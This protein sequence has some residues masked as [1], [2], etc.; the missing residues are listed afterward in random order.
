MAG[1]KSGIIPFPE[2]TVSDS[3]KR[4]I[5]YGTQVAQAIESEWWR[6][7]SGVG[8]SIGSGGQSSAGG[9]QYNESR[10]HYHTLRLYARGEQSVQRYKDEFAASGDLSYL[11]L[12][13]KP[14][15][16]VPKFV[17]VVVNGM[18]DRLFTIKADAIDPIATAERTKF[19]EM[20]EEDMNSREFTAGVGQSLGIDISNFPSEEQT[21]NSEELELYMQIGY[22]Q[23]IEVAIEQA[24]ENV[25]KQNNYHRI[26]R[27]LDEDQMVLG[28]SCAKHGF[29][30]TDGITVEYVDPADLIYSYTEDPD[31]TDC[32][33]FGEVRRI[34]ANELKKQLPHL[35]DA[36]L[37]EIIEKGNNS[38]NYNVVDY[39]YEDD[40]DTNQ[41]QVM[42]FNWKTWENNVYKIK[43]TGTGGKKAVKKDDSFNPPKDKRAHFERVAEAN[44]V[45]YEGMY[46]LGSKEVISWK[47][48]EN[49]VR[50]DSN[51]NQVLMNYV[52]AASKYYKGRTESL[53][54]RMRT[55][56]DLIQLTHLKIQ[57]AIQRMTPSG[58]FLNADALADI[59]LGNGTSYNPQ[60]AL[61]MYFQTGSV[62][63]RSLNMEGDQSGALPIQPLP[64]SGGEQIQILIGA[65]NHYIAQ[66]QEMTGI[67][68]ARD[69]SDPDPYSLVGVQKLAAANSNTATRHIQDSVMNIT[70]TVA[71]AIVSRF[72]D[73]VEYHPEK[74]ALIGAI[75]RF[76]VGSLKELQKMHLHDFG[77]F[78]ELD[79]DEEEKQYVEANIQAALA[80]E[81]ITLEDAIDVRQI[82]N[83]KLANELLKVRRRRKSAEDHE[84][85]MQLVDQ[86]TKGNQEASQAAEMAKAQAEAIKNESA[87]Q[88]EQLKNELGIKTLQIETELEK[89]K[90]QYKHTLDLELKDKELS[91]QKEIARINAS[92]APNGNSGPTKPAAPISPLI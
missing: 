13:W 77:I 40:Y 52:V 37:A 31:F 71:E 22:K 26:K 15:P 50:P 59:D 38:V 1:N 4:S 55:Y 82:N 10:Y 92:D 68:S 83:I 28:I 58:V 30:N 87:G 8:N 51:A 61:N 74:E 7:D 66:I 62:I 49:M 76:S 54:E 48:V 46:I 64:G 79:P 9:G 3:V 89:E 88:L 19:V 42:Y 69:G 75:G 27:R 32:Y 63:G 60:E 35:T 65:Y 41:L 33:Y 14:V 39:A 16:I 24:V 84:K 78:L 6:Q 70:T 80:R 56:A 85:Q 90:M 21:E 5:E 72:K 11:N 29:N 18:Q 73:V 12:D 43:D 17:D 34:T 23:G 81:S 36:K 20:M 47:R 45:I 44:E 67:N 25:M 53:V 91:S 57:Q 2:Q 86:Q